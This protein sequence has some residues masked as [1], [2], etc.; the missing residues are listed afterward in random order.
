MKS[1]GEKNQIKHFAYLF[2][3][4]RVSSN[5]TVTKLVVPPESPNC[6][7]LPSLP[8]LLELVKFEHFLQQRSFDDF[9]VC[10][11]NDINDMLIL[12]PNIPFCAL[13]IEFTFE[14]WDS[15]SCEAK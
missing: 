3:C 9:Q 13:N 1:V 4:G 11:S 12:A 7:R 14:C 6:N 2:T 10:N 15:L 8:D 5:L